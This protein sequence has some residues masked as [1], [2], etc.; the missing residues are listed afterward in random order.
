[1]LHLSVC[2]A[3]VS[4]PCLIDLIFTEYRN[5]IHAH[6]LPGRPYAQILTL[7]GDRRAPD[8]NQPAPAGAATNAGTPF[9]PVR[10]RL[11][12]IFDDFKKSLDKEW[13]P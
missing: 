11:R 8:N 13:Y 10:G 1:L 4:P 9:F 5:S 7:R 3:L 6:Y 2:R 12:P